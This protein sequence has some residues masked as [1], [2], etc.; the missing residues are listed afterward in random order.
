MK[1]KKAS[2]QKFKDEAKQKGVNL[3][4]KTRFGTPR[5]H[6]ICHESS[7]GIPY[8]CSFPAVSENGLCSR[9]HR[10]I[11]GAAYF[12]PDEL[13]VLKTDSDSLRT[14]A[15]TCKAPRLLVFA[16]IKEVL[17]YREKY[18]ELNEQTDT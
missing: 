7:S 2:L 16:L 8:Q 18:G 6:H 1:I 14:Y 12:P 10:E 17:A 4:S 13:K 11:F 9:H 5:C 15:R 3:V